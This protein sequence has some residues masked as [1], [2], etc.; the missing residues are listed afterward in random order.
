MI[1]FKN[2]L[3]GYIKMFEKKYLNISY[4]LN[5]SPI[6]NVRYGKFIAEEI[7]QKMYFSILKPMFDKSFKSTDDFIT[8]YVLNYF[9]TGPGHEFEL[10]ELGTGI[11]L[12]EDTLLY[13]LL[14][15]ISSTFPD[16][17]ISTINEKMSKH[18][19]KQIY[20]KI[21][22]TIEH[23]IAILNDKVTNYQQKLDLLSKK[24]YFRIV[25]DL[26]LISSNYSEYFPEDYHIYSLKKEIE[27]LKFIKDNYVDMIYKISNQKEINLNNGL[28]RYTQEQID[29]LMNVQQLTFLVINELCHNR[30]LNNQDEIKLALLYKIYNFINSNKEKNIS[31]FLYLGNINLLKKHNL[32][33]MAFT[34][35]ATSWGGAN[36]LFTINDLEELINFLLSQNQEVKKQFDLIKSIPAE[37]FDNKNRNESLNYLKNKLEEAIEISKI[38]GAE[39]VRLEDVMQSAIEQ[40]KQENISTDKIRRLDLL[41]KRIEMVL[42]EMK[43]F[44]TQRADGKFK[45]FHVFYYQT[46]MVA[47][48]KLNDEYGC[49]YIMPINIYISI[50]NNNKINNLY[51]IRKIPGVI[52]IPHSKKNWK[53]EAKKIIF[54]SNITEEQLKILDN[55]ATIEIPVSE[56][57]LDAFI[58]LYKN[59]A[60]LVNEAKRRKKE[61][62]KKLE[63]IDEKL[64]NDNANDD[65]SQIINDAEEELM[66]NVE[67]PQD[68]LA[69]DERLLKTKTKRNAWVSLN[70]KL[71]TLD[72]RGAM[73]CEMCGFESLDTRNFESHHIIPL[74]ENGIDNLYNTVCLC[75]NCHN[76][77]H[78]KL[79]PTYSQRWEMLCNVRKNIEQSTPYYLIKFDRL[80]NP[81]YNA[82]Y[83]EININEE[84][85]K[86]KNQ[87]IYAEED[88]YYKKHKEEEDLKF[89]YEWNSKKR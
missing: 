4:F 30:Y 11:K 69:F 7:T 35:S 77:I 85:N 88:E 39:D 66:N 8:T 32:E 59:N 53:E 51:D 60:I 25:L 67:N 31:L 21:E 1:N 28:S 63:E 41:I 61:I 71:R 9:I 36:E 2:S 24:G 26:Q 33:C 49:L 14:Y 12:N 40:R 76:K 44:K 81:N 57:E 84:K 79:P 3:N 13:G 52:P 58:E 6:S 17:F 29:L 83:H 5:A 45:G 70:T 55:V 72:K 38:E 18:E 37:N 82:M 43:P 65:D 87:K 64:R 20:I 54:N 23:I 56:K 34:L 89:I 78:S 10:N 22:E 16:L 50:L 48:D 75:G 42:K 46:G 27:I 47:I 68:T 74:S 62:E 80:F 73:H 19:K 86:Y 15:S